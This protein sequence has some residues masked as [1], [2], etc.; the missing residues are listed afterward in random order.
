MT[1]RNCSH[2]H[3]TDTEKDPMNVCTDTA[4]TCF[5]YE[6]ATEYN[7]VVQEWDKYTK[8]FETCKEQLIWIM[9]NLKYTRNL[10]NKTFVDFV[11]SK[12]K[13]YDPET[14]RRTKQKLVELYPER[15]GPFNA[16]QFEQ[17]KQFK[18]LAIEEW[19]LQ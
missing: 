4:C 9:D 13:D 5:N 6:N 12:V 2:I 16:D 19:V 8:E 15:F 10:K 11:R 17:E 3:I 7:P 1:C 14:I 18:Q